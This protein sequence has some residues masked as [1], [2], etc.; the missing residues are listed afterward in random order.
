[1]IPKQAL[2]RGY[3]TDKQD[4]EFLE[5]IIDSRILEAAITWITLEFSPEDLYAK[6][7][8]GA[9]AENNGYI[10]DELK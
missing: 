10:K 8:L 7:I 3:T 2:A 9:W 1:M 6:S 4:K 5:N